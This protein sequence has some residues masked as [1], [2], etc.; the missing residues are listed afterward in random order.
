MNGTA[1]LPLHICSRCKSHTLEPEDRLNEFEREV[2][3]ELNLLVSA[4][5]FR[6]NKMGT[7]PSGDPL[8]RI[9]AIFGLKPSPQLGTSVA[10]QFVKGGAVSVVG[11]NNAAINAVATE[12]NEKLQRAVAQ[13]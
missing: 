1:E 9:V 2:V 12:V 3:E 6:A 8:F 10:D 4:A 13:L 7:L 11:A 5:S